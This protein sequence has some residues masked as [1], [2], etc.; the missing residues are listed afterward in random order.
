MNHPIADAATLSTLNNLAADI[1]TATIGF[2]DFLDRLGAFVA[3][4]L[5]IQGV[6]LTAAET[7]TC[8]KTNVS[9]QMAA[10]VKATKLAATKPVPGLSETELEGLRR[11]GLS[12]RVALQVKA[13]QAKRRAMLAGTD[14]AHT[15]RLDPRPLRT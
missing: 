1:S 4:E 6:A 3:K 10:R 14:D 11:S 13:A 7:A 2:P 15:S 8:A 12:P 9:P 5:Q